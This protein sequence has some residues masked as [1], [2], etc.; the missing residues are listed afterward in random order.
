MFTYTESNIKARCVAA[1]TDDTLVPVM[2]MVKFPANRTQ[3]YICG[4]QFASLMVTELDELG[5]LPDDSQ[6]TEYFADD[7]GRFNF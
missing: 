5:N 3:D 6:P 4:L 1:I 7:L 2:G